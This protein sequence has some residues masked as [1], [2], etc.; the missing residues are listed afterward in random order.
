MTLLFLYFLSFNPDTSKIEYV[1]PCTWKCSCSPVVHVGWMVRKDGKVFKLEG[2]R[3]DGKPV[4][5]LYYIEEKKPAVPQ[6]HK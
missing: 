5:D 2:E 4:S 3:K 6:Q 1:F